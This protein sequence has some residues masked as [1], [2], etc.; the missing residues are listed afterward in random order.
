MPNVDA[1][2]T[3]AHLTLLAKGIVALSPNYPL[4]TLP[5]VFLSKIPEKR[6]ADS[7]PL[8]TVILVEGIL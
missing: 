6:G 5:Y 3:L 4:C 7:C 2:L 8:E 1:A